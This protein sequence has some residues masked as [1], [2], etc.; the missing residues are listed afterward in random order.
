MVPSQGSNPFDA[1]LRPLH[2]YAERAGLNV[3]ELANEMAVQ[4]NILP[5]KIKEVVSKG[6]DADGLVLFLDQMEEL[7][8]VQH[9]DHV[10]SFLSELYKTV[11]EAKFRVV[12]TIRSDILHHCHEHPEMLQ[13][14][15]GPAHYPLGPVAAYMMRDMIAK[16][17]Q[18]AGLTI[19]V[20]LVN[21]LIKESGAEQGNLPLLAFVLERLF[22]KRSSDTLSESVYDTLGGVGGAIGEHLK[23]VETKRIK[24]K[25]GSD[26]LDRLPR[27][28]QSL[29]VVNEEGQ[30]TR[31]RVPV[32]QF[33]EDLR[34]LVDILIP[35]RLLSTEGEGEA[36]TV[37]LAHEKLTEAWPALWKWIGDN[38]RDLFELRQAEREAVLWEKSAFDLNYL[39]R[40]ERLKVLQEIL[41]KL[42]DRKVDPIVK[43]YAAPQDK[44]VERLKNESISHQERI[45]IGQ[46][47]AELGDTRSSVGV[48]P[49]DG[50]PD[51]AWVDIEPGEVKLEDV[52]QVFNVEKPFRISKYP[53]TNAQFEAFIK[54]AGYRNKEWWKDIKQIEEPWEPSWREPNS[55]RETVSWFEAVAFCRWLTAKYRERGSLVETQEIRLPTEWE[56]QLAATGGDAKRKY[57]WSGGWDPARCNSTESRLNRTT[58]VGMYP[59]GATQQGVLDMVGNVWEWCLNKY[60]EPGSPKSL[61]INN[62]ERGLRVVRGGS[63]F[64]SPELLRTSYRLWYFASV[65]GSDIGFRLAQSTL[66]ANSRSQRRK[67]AEG[68]SRS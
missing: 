34:G 53:V 20:T 32:A 37:S 63:W 57:P 42:S 30:P 64:S 14:L 48:C 2:G 25:L 47:L 40:V 49:E 23:E 58:S 12:A 19:P 31:R 16:P 33:T 22:D 61:L 1:L 5:D 35:A 54:E 18:C 9:R 4:P 50:L 17:A 46:Y 62:D 65:R 68:K 15:R 29:L 7:F 10:G 36:A 27:V 21:R 60:E 3:F 41:K 67:E 45:T 38:K 51:I 44:L 66:T 26:A 43:I 52:E 28:F 39:W 24:E 56:W 55:S 6:I 8:T 13:V 11:S 59:S